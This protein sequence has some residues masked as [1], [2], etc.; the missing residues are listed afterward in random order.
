[1]I[2][3]TVFLMELPTSILGITGISRLQM[4]VP[5]EEMVA[6]EDRLYGIETPFT[7][8]SLQTMPFPHTTFKSPG[9]PKLT[10]ANLR[11]CNGSTSQKEGDCMNW[12][13]CTVLASYVAWL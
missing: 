9:F 6:L 7:F 4:S 2:W 8:F 12:C 13:L 11:L 1:M 5:L 3:M 10:L